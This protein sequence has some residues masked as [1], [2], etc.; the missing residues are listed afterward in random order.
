MIHN[1]HRYLSHLNDKM[2]GASCKS[3]FPTGTQIWWRDCNNGPS[4]H[5]N[6]QSQR[7]KCYHSPQSTGRSTLWNWNLGESL[8]GLKQVTEASG[9]GFKAAREIEAN[10]SGDCP[11]HGIDVFILRMRNATDKSRVCSR[12]KICWYAQNV[13]KEMKLHSKRPAGKPVRENLDIR[14]Y[15]GHNGF[16]PTWSI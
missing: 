4:G 16:S 6:Q 1:I 15:R 13:W 2:C 11:M 3:L 7:Q 5:M 12:V 10:W 9:R 8:I 14:D